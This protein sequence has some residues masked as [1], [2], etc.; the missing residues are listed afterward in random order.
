MRIRELSK[1]LGLSNNEILKKLEELGVVGKKPASGLT[2]EEEEMLR[3]LIAEENKAKDLP[4]EEHPKEKKEKKADKPKEAKPENK[5]QQSKAP[6]QKA[7]NAQQSAEPKHKNKKKNKKNKQQPAPAPAPAPEPEEDDISVIE[8]PPSVT[9]GELAERIGKKPTEIIMKLMAMGVMASIN[10]EID[11]DTCEKICEDYDI[12]VEEEV[13]KDIAEEMF[14]L[15]ED[16]PESLK[17][18][19]PVVVVMG[20]VDH[21]KTSLLDSIRKTKVTEGE[22]G[23]ITQHIGAYT[24]SINKKPITFLDTPGHEAFTAMRMRGAMVTDIAVLVVAADDGVMPQTIEAINHAKAAGVEIIVAIN[25]IDKPSANPDRVKQELIEYGLVA[26]DWGGDTICVP[27]SAV[28]KEGIDQLLEMITLVAEMKEL[29]ANPDKL[30]IGTI[31]EARLD[32]GRG[33]VA[34]ALVKGGT[35]HV[36]DPMVVGSTYGRVRAMVDD[37]GR[38]IKEAGPSKPV[39][40]LGLNDVPHAGDTFYVAKTDKQARQVAESV[41][42]KAKIDML[43]DT[44]KVSLE[45][46]FSQIQSGNM[47]ELNIVIKADVQ[48]SVE[49]VKASLEKLSNDEVRIRTIHGGV[50]AIT[51]SDVMLA[52]ASNAII[53]GFNVR[54]ESSAKNVAED[55]Q[56]DIRLYR[57][58]YNAIDDITAAM[59]G[60]L[61]PE[62]EE[63]ILGHAEVRQIFHASGVGTIA[64]SYVKDGKITRNSK[65]RLLRDNVIVYEG[66]VATLR[67]YKDD[68]K[69]VASN[70]E[71]GILLNKFNDVKAGDIIEAFIMEEIKQ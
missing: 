7:Q 56:V 23:G 25:K 45:D 46:L 64:G 3:E 14:S 54:P 16:S 13:E 27:V 71:C 38:Q 19:P 59:Q 17:E 33:P 2:A 35:L 68:V 62:F 8:L 12:I 65:V 57:V 40:I 1:E 53:I 51:E 22:A 21:G 24:V 11:R 67:R 15:E 69:E 32:K 26:E 55:Q 60:M 36:S 20:H 4:K 43:K 39:E 41:I 30:A 29:K 70:Y 52:S 49:A 50:G 48:G 10:N 61:D 58:I 9:V 6:E 28:T 31:I 42:A 44:Q 18:R 5:P 66:E 47:K 63:R 37:K 34:T